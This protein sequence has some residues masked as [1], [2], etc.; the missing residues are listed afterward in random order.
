MSYDPEQKDPQG[1]EV[2]DTGDSDPSDDDGTE[3]PFAAEQRRGRERML[4]MWRAAVRGVAEAAQRAAASNDG[5]PPPEPTPSE[6]A[7][8]AAAAEPTFVFPPRRAPGGSRN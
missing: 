3:T 7:A 4:G 1:V 5:K 8:P 6:D 2:T